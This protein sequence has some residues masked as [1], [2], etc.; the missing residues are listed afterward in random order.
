MKKSLND[1][2]ETVKELDG[3]R[4]QSLAILGYLKSNGVVCKEKIKISEDAEDLCALA[5][6]SLD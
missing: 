4:E 6:C 3:Y 1:L 5:G 2:I